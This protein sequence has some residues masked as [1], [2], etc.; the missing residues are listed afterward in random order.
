MIKDMAT[1]RPGLC[2]TVLDTVGALV[3]VLDPQ[4]RIVGF[5]RVCEAV[6]G[7]R[8]DE[9]QGLLFFDLF[10]PPEA[11][12]G[13]R[14]VFSDLCAG[15]FPNTHENDWVTRG[16]NRRRI[17]WTNA[18]ILDAAGSVE[19]VVGT[20]IDVTEHRQGEIAIQ[21]AKQEWEATFDAVPD[22][23]AVVGTDMRIKRV[24]RALAER[25][26]CHPGDLVGKRCCETLHG[27]AGEPDWCL[28][29]RLLSQGCADSVESCES[30]LDGDYQISVTPL[31]EPDG[32]L[33]G[34]VHVFRDITP[35][36]QAEAARRREELARLDRVRSLGILSLALAHELNQPL[37]AILLNAQTALRLITMHAEPP[38]GEIGDMLDDIVR[39]DKR[40]ALIIEGMRSIFEG[41]PMP[42]EQLCLAEV[43]R[44]AE[45]LLRPEAVRRG[46]ALCVDAV[47]DLPGVR[48]GLAALLQVLVNLALNAFDAVGALPSERCQVWIAAAHDGDFVK[49]SVHDSG[50][51]IAPDRLETIFELLLTGKE[52]GLGMGLPISR[53]L[54]EAYGGTLVAG[55]HPAGGAVFTFTLPVAS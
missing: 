54:V 49:V 55:N 36:K 44:E 27:L 41:R 39:D 32:T 52:Y 23:V 24:N 1:E 29:K 19:F 43:L 2:A 40:A 10:V 21:R 26:D 38:I 7:Y 18:A 11:V 34:S 16:G 17:L 3:I 12:E 51:G 5:N 13:V 15:H 9:V 33:R 14:S 31:R 8:F 53:S 37:A 28:H 47:A 6:T 35:L 46:V 30:R 50:P 42:A 48:A 45:K 4:G 20:G 22:L 25:L